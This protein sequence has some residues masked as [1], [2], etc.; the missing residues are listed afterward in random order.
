MTARTVSKGAGC[1]WQAKL[2]RQLYYVSRGM[3]LASS[4]LSL[5][6][7]G[8]LGGLLLMVVIVGVRRGQSTAS[9]SG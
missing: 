3:T 9:S 4:P 7:C 1:T 5:T 8:K 2:E 6:P